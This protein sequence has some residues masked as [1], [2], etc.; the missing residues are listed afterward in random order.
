MPRPKGLPKTGGRTKGLP[1]KNTRDIK[2]VALTLTPKS[3]K[4]LEKLLDSENE[5]VAMAAIKEVH[6]RAYGKAPQP[7]GGG[8]GTQPMRLIIETGVPR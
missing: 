8:D 4:R 7:V 6:E 2:A 3:V 1:N 5:T